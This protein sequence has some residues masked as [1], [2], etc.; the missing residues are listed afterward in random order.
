MGVQMI[1]KK[2]IILDTNFLLIPSQFNVDIFAEIERIA[3]FNYELCIFDKTIYE[4]NKIINE[5]KGKHKLSAKLALAIIKI[6]KIK[7]LKSPA[8]NVD[9]ILEKQKDAVIATS[10]KGLI[11]KLKNK[12]IKVIRLMQKKY[13]RFS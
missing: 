2:R 8:G 9:E 10:D 7:V 4:L 1:T 6:K 5:Q 12:R 11:N 13:L 3:D